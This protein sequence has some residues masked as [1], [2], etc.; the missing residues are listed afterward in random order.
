MVTSIGM[1][2]L[3]GYS[4]DAAG[5]VVGKLDARGAAS[6]MM[7]KTCFDDTSTGRVAIFMRY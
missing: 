6:V 3:N 4:Q 7:Q 2:A 1:D 5:A